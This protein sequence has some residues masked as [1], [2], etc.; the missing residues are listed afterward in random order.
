LPPGGSRST[1][2]D[3]ASTLL[4][5]HGKW[6]H[7]YDSAFRWE[8]SSAEG[9]EDTHLGE[10]AVAAAGS[11]G[12]VRLGHQRMVTPSAYRAITSTATIPP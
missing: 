5:S 3:F 10:Q 6:S 11:A 8:P 12:G 4:P 9:T 1:S 7:E 2:S